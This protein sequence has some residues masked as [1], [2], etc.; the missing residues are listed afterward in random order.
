MAKKDP[1]EERKRRSERKGQLGH[2]MEDRVPGV[3]RKAITEQRIDL[4]RIIRHRK[5][6]PEHKAGFDYTI[7]RLLNG[8]EQKLSFGITISKENLIRIQW[9][10]PDTIQFFFSVKCSDIWIEKK[11]I[12]LTTRNWYSR[13]WEPVISV[14]DTETEPAQVSMWLLPSVV[15]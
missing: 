7:F 1:S 5:G 6:S 13:F 12:S 3:V 4:L 9:C 11:I 10:H 8:Q 2:Q 15:S 14:N